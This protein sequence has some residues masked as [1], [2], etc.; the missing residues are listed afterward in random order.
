MHRWD[1]TPGV[2]HADLIKVGERWLRSHGCRVVLSEQTVDSGEV[3]DIIGWRSNAHSIV[4]ECKV[5]RS[6]FLADQKKASRNPEI[7]MGCERLYLVPKG[8]LTKFDLPPGW[9]LLEYH[10]REVQLAFR[11]SSRSCRK[12]AGFVS[13]MKLLVASLRRVEVRIEPQTITDFLKWKNRMAEYNGGQ[14]PEG[15]SSP[16][17]EAAQIF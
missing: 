8:L 7:G 2:T 11:P 6:D 14:L 15:L 12:E 16:E 3:P 9:G 5:S 1:R 4:I 10:K 13:E 17:E